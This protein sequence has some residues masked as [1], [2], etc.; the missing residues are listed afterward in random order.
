MATSQRP[1]NRRELDARLDVLEPA[2]TALQ[3]KVSVLEQELAA[4]AERIRKLEGQQAK[5]LVQ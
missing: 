4:L 2:F 1:P 5:V 3:V